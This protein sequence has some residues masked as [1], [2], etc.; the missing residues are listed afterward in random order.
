MCSVALITLLAFVAQA[1]G[2]E[3]AAN[4]MSDS[5]MD[6]LADQFMVKLANKLVD[7]VLKETSFVDNEDLDTS[8]RGKPGNLDSLQDGSRYVASYMAPS[9]SQEPFS[10]EE[11]EREEEEET[12]LRLLLGLRGGA[13]KAAM[14]A[15]AMKAAPKPSPMKAMKAAKPKAAMKAAMKA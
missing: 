13:K 14:K 11:L 12:K 6:E 4:Q 15:A 8:T 1:H 5:Q 10:E 7:R 9:A 2:E 3:A